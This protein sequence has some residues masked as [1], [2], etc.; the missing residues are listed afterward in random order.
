MSIPEKFKIK[1]NINKYLLKKSFKNFLPDEI[2]NRQ[3][4]GFGSPINIWLRGDLG[5][6]VMDEV[7][8]VN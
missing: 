2:L 1:N 6:I 5:K 3:K 8:I 4:Q 7:L